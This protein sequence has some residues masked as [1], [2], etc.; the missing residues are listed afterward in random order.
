MKTLL[1]YGVRFLIVIDDIDR[2]SPDEALLVKAAKQRDRLA[3]DAT[4]ARD[5]AGR[6]R[7]P[8]SLGPAEDRIQLV[9]ATVER[10]DEIVVPTQE[11]E[12]IDAVLV[13][14]VRRLEIRKFGP[15]KARKVTCPARAD[16]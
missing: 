12:D 13:D 5:Q 2:L 8:A 4:F 10:A 15:R 7:L 3:T 14:G 9:G 6:R 11:P 1:C 16:R